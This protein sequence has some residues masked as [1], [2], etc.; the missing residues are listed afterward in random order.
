MPAALTLQYCD[1]KPEVP[2]YHQIK[3]L[4]TKVPLT[5][6]PLYIDEQFHSK[7]TQTSS[8][9]TKAAEKPDS[10]R[11]IWLQLSMIQHLPIRTL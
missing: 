11:A 6:Y 3:M 9:E 1:S 10:S 4:R 5:C 7:G 2:A 8:E